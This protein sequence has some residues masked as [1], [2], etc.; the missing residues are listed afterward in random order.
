MYVFFWIIVGCL[1][2]LLNDPAEAGASFKP[3]W[4]D[5]QNWGGSGS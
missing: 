1:P 3:E 2:S 4:D 5:A